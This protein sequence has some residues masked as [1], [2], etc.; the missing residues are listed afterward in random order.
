M[1]ETIPY[2]IAKAIH[3]RVRHRMQTEGL[4]RRRHIESSFKGYVSAW[5]GPPIR[6]R[7]PVVTVHITALDARVA[8]D[9]GTID[10]L[11]RVRCENA[12]RVCRDLV[13]TGPQS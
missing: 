8:D 13:E 9:T 12:M 2:S 4:L 10:D 6:G 11:V 1:T 7:H 5:Y 3:G